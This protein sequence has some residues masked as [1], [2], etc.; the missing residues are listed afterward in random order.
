MRNS[1]R[2]CSLFL[3]LFT[4]SGP[5]FLVSQTVEKE[6]DKL[7]SENYS[8]SK[9]GA[10]AL[11]YKDGKTLYRKAIG[12]AN[13]ELQV[14]MKPENVF[15]IGSI[16]KQFTAVSILMLVEQDKL[17]LDDE[18]TKFIPDYPTHGKRITV[19]HLLNHTSGIKSY[20]SIPSFMDVAR[21][22]M[23]PLELVD[24]FKNEP[25][26]FDPGEKWL[27]NN[28]GYVL[29]GYIIEKVSGQSYPNFIEEH[30][31]KKLGMKNSYY[32]SESQ[33]IP[34]RA[35]GYS[36]KDGGFQN[37]DYLS[38]T[39]P[40]AAGSIMSNIDD[41][42]LWNKAV[43]DNK[44][45]T[46]ESKELAF[47]NSSLNNGDLTNYGYGWMMNEISGVPSI[48]HG[49]GIFGY[50]TA[51]IYVPSE[52]VYVI[53][54]T[55]QDGVSPENAAIKMAALALGK[56]YLKPNAAISLTTEQLSKW[57]GN[58]EFEGDVIRTISLEDGKL[59]SQREGSEKLPLF[60][61]LENQLYFEEGT[62]HYEFSM[63]NGKKV[64]RL[65][66]RMQKA[67]G[68]ETDKKSATEKE[69]IEI[70]TNM[71]PDYVGRFEMAP[72]FIITITT[73]DGKLFAQAT[74]QPQFEVFPEAEDTFFLKVV[75]AKLVF[76]R[77]ETGKVSEVTLFQG[78]QEIKG[79]KLE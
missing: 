46:K 79:Q 78:G 52:N 23:K 43:H 64:T 24:F 32:G 18:I 50:V 72:N 61:V 36:P 63:E 7:L 9:P 67:K 15:E 28:S 38:M 49:G 8:V 20:T 10:T 19:Q 30:I 57:I 1:N 65:Q 29:L 21:K 39:L 37:A 26:D 31:F 13:I 73:A 70:D 5:I 59:Y 22:D 4:L 48:E 69:V 54:L 55:N 62:S 71:L 58:Y 40:Y 51:G 45:I 77:N 6:F 35:S 75:A 44:L 33:I 76:R 12:M 41:M 34:D 66:D 27:Y 11:V 68:M 14:P 56:P 53:I 74:G 42:L 16:T 60:A 2:L 47:T 3:L 17:K 25:M